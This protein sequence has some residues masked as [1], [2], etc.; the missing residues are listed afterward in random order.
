MRSRDGGQPPREDPR[1]ERT[2]ARLRVAALE[3]L[4]AVGWGGFTVEGVA[5]RAG[6]GKASV[7]RL[8]GE[9]TALVVDAFAH[10]VVQPRAADGGPPPVREILLHLIE[11]WSSPLLPALVDAAMREP[12]L[13]AALRPGFAGR[14]DGLAAAV[15]VELAAR[16]DD[17]DPHAVAR[18]L[19]GAL[20][21]RR[22]VVPGSL[23][24]TD[25]DEA[26][27][28]VLPPR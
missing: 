8:Y 12:D 21:Y 14:L 3:E 15:A 26:L 16:G 23:V 4:V 7:Y 13:A 20:L 25:A 28:A 17:R 10:L 19:A 27:A 24:P 6:A 9:R 22:L 18:A 5:R 2:R 1:I 11:G